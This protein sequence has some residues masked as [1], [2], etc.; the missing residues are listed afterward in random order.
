MSVLK[1]QSYMCKI[2]NHSLL[3]MQLC[4]QVTTIVFHECIED[5]ITSSIINY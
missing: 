5:T 2:N 4:V 3:E 1:I